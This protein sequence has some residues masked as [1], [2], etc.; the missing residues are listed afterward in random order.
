MKSDTK[1]LAKFGQLPNKPRSTIRR[2]DPPLAASWL[3]SSHG[4]RRISQEHVARLAEQMKAGQWQITHQ[5]IA[6]DCN[7]N[8]I[9]GHHTLWAILLSG[10]SVDLMVTDNLRPE[11]IKVI[12]TGKNRTLQD[13]LTLLKSWGGVSRGEAA[14]LKRMVRGRAK[15]MRRS[16]TDECLDWELNHSHVRFAIGMT[17]GLGSGIRLAALR[18]VVARAHRSVSGEILQKFCWE[19]KANKLGCL[20]EKI[21]GMSDADTYDSVER[22]LWSYTNSGIEMPDGKGF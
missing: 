19:L 18:A 16:A 20:L 14:C 7:K 13:R 15:T 21:R 6:F 11:T 1:I 3:E 22:R 8:L 9:D 4:N 5:G 10:V 12:D 2:V 17:D